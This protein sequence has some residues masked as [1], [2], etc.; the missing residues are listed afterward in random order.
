MPWWHD[1]FWGVPLFPSWKQVGHEPKPPCGARRQ[2]Y[3]H[4]TQLWRPLLLGQ[5]RKPHR[6]LRVRPECCIR[7]QEDDVRTNRVD[8]SARERGRRS[9]GSRNPQ[10]ARSIRD[11][12]H[13]NFRGI[14]QN[15][16]PGRGGQGAFLYIC[17]VCRHVCLRH[18]NMHVCVSNEE[19]KYRYDK[20]HLNGEQPEVGFVVSYQGHAPWLLV[21]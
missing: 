13:G 21:A 14:A 18:A 15:Q 16:P 4:P 11:I 1:P 5:R 19:T 7:R 9:D 8:C 6:N 3:D 20:A 12:P 17:S 10:V 2:V